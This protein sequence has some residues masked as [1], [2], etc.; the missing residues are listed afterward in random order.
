MSSLAR[1]RRR[2]TVLEA[3]G[4]VQLWLGVPFYQVSNQINWTRPHP[5]SI[6]RYSPHSRPT[7]PPPW[8]AVRPM[9]AR[10]CLTCSRAPHCARCLRAYRALADSESSVS[11][12]SCPLFV[13]RF[14]CRARPCLPCLCCMIRCLSHFC[15]HR[16][17][18][19]R[20]PSP[21]LP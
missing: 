21:F 19:A 13:C 5:K 17:I 20:V 8:V 2:S 15:Q 3:P 12:L 11:L 16:L 14:C 1:S 7:S 4:M 18:F 10:A 9:H 6:A